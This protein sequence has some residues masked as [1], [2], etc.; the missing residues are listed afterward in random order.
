MIYRRFL[1]LN[2][3][4]FAPAFWISFSAK[5]TPSSIM[6]GG[7]ILLMALKAIH[8]NELPSR[9]IIEDVQKNYIIIVYSIKMFYYIDNDTFWPQLTST[10]ILEINRKT[11]KITEYLEK[12]SVLYFCL[13]PM[14]LWFINTQR[15]GDLNT[16]CNSMGFLLFPWAEFYPS[17]G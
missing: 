1:L 2:S 17:Y 12:S 3:F 13:F 15:F 14:I 4:I 11:P 5:V 7:F 10:D 6:Q 16:L 8:V 9:L